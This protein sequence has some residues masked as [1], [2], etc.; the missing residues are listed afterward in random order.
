MHNHYFLGIGGIG[1]SALARYLHRE[2]HVVAGYDKTPTPLTEQLQKEG[3]PIYFDDA[4]EVIPE[5]FTQADQTLVIRTPAVPMEHRGFTWF[6]DKGFT[7][8]KRAALLG[9]IVNELRPLCVAGT[10]GKTTTSSLLAWLLHASSVPM[11][12]FLGGI[13][14]NFK[15]NYIGDEDPE[16]AVVEADEFDRS[17]MHLRPY[18][19]I[20]T[21][22]DADHLDIY[23]TEEE[24]LKTYREFAQLVHPNGLLVMRHGLPIRPAGKVLTYGIEQ[25]DVQARNVRT[26]DG[27]FSFEL[28]N[29]TENTGKWFMPLPGA[30]NVENA[31]AAI[32]VA[33][34]CGASIDALKVA[35]SEFAGVARR[36]EKVASASHLVYY[37]DY[38]HHP[39]ELTAAIT[40][41]KTLYPDQPITGIFQPHL[42][43]R[44]QDFADGFAASLSLLD[45]VVLMDIYPA[46]EKP[47]PGVTSEMLLEKIKGPK[48]QIRASATAIIENV[49]PKTQGVLV[50][51]GAGDIDRLV[52]T[53][54]RWI[55]DHQP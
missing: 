20:L 30:H 23:G 29:H 25:G 5:A 18:M 16:F 55:Q 19:A 36:M 50:T 52:P 44:T 22:V 3:I 12:A 8:L 10:H 40:A 27:G 39:A 4:A 35:L 37:D 13:P 7:I 54:R 14:A 42:F 2:G 38:A 33:K 15:T 41:L 1:M 45:H 6:R 43:S 32:T 31:L 51:L 46:R 24:L 28:W 17:F 21:A 49:L 26:Q 9:S 34:A 53:I 48:T 47:I 11:A